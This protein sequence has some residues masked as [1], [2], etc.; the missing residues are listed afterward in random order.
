MS[1]KCKRP[2]SGELV[3]QHQKVSVPIVYRGVTVRIKHRLL[4]GIYQP[5]YYSGSDPP[6]GDG[7]IFDAFVV[8]SVF[9][10]VMG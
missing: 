5:R 10:E 1:I 4:P 6:F 2:T 8:T 3:S 9:V 7:P